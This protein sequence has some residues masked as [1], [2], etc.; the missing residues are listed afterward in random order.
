MPAIIRGAQDGFQKNLVLLK[1]PDKLKYKVGE[2]LDFSGIKL[3]VNFNGRTREVTLDKITFSPSSNTIITKD[4]TD[5]ITVSYREYP[6]SD[7]IEI[8]LIITKTLFSKL[9]VSVTPSIGIY[10]FD[11]EF[12]LNNVL[13]TT[14]LSILYSDGSMEKFTG[15]ITG[16]NIADKFIFTDANNGEAYY[17]DIELTTDFMYENTAQ[18][19]TL[20]LYVSDKPK[21]ITIGSVTD[22]SS[23][24]YALKM[25]EAHAKGI[26]DIKNFWKVGDL[27]S[28]TLKNQI[29]GW[30]SKIEFIIQAID[31]NIYGTRVNVLFG[32]KQVVNVALRTCRDNS[33]V[34]GYANP[35]LIGKTMGSMGGVAEFLRDNIPEFIQ[36]NMK[37]ITLYFT[38]R[39]A[40]ENNFYTEEVSL[41]STTGKV[42]PY[43]RIL[44]TGS[45]DRCGESY[46]TSAIQGW[47][48]S[49]ARQARDKV[50]N[51][52][53]N[54]LEGYPPISQIP[55]FKTE[56]NRNKY[57]YDGSACPYCLLDY[58]H[59][60]VT[61]VYGSNTII[62]PLAYI[63]P[64]GY[65]GNMDKGQS[66][67]VGDSY[68]FCL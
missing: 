58:N 43:T 12:D 11:E 36:N 1:K 48:E 30:P 47:E 35:S 29:A 59:K 68:F 16:C 52:I 6:D 64:Y 28:V 31:F 32:M 61:G 24:K 23:W 65:G 13:N 17:K 46:N 20:S 67:E 25:I 37:N 2:K 3:G 62:G 49:A 63:G 40:R 5:I 15:N 66:Y 39:L 51:D 50:K 10:H 34:Y 44:V 56:S 9:V 7:P 18:K 45:G 53:L 57:K 54:G 22:E 26:I 27:L 19:A 38:K 60:Y 21:I 42:L 33:T 55:Y 14:G 41:Q 4:T 8:P